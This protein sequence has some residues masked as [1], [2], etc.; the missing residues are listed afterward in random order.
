MKS[1][2]RFYS[3]V[4]CPIDGVYFYILDLPFSV[5]RMADPLLCRGL[6][7]LLLWCL[8]MKQNFLILIRPYQS[9]PFD[10]YFVNCLGSP[11]TT[12]SY[13][14]VPHSRF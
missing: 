11:H 10:Y 14:D 3:Y 6:S 7:P 2:A 13:E 1:L 5:V 9:L 12:Y 4:L 8:F